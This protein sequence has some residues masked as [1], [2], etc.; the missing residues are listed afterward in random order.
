MNTLLLDPKKDKNT[1]EYAAD[2]LKKGGLV[3][4]PTETVYGLAADA[5][6]ENA[7]KSIYEA[8][9]RPSD[10]PLI[11]HIAQFEDIFPLVKSVPD[12]AKKLAES[13]WPG[14]LTIILPKSDKIPHCTSGG[15]DTVAIRMPSHPIARAVIKASGLPLAAPSANISGFPSPSKAEYA[16]DDMQ[17]RVP[18]VI[19]GGDCEVGVESTVI[20]LAAETPTVLRP[21]GI[22]VEQLKEV[23]G[24]V[25]VDDAVL[26]PL[27]KDASA[28]SPGMKY[29]HYSPKTQVTV[30]RGTEKGYIRYLLSHKQDGMF[31]L[32]FEE[33]ADKIP[34]PLI[35]YGKK[36]EP[37]T[38]SRRLFD[39][40]RELDEH[41]A[42]TAIAQC[43]SQN[44]L[45]LAVCN[46]LFRSAGFKFIYEAPIIGLTGQSG[47]GKSTVAEIFAENGF[48]IIDCDKIAREV[49]DDAEVLK[50]LSEQFGADILTED[51]KLNRR[52]L[53]EKAFS[54]AENTNKLNAVVHPAIL[55]KTVNA[56]YALS[57]DNIPCVIDAPL[58]F[59]C[60]LDE[61]CCLSVC[62]TAD[63]NVRLARI[64]KRDNIS[65]QECLKRFSI[66][67]TEKYY[68]DNADIIINNCANND[69]IADVRCKIKRIKDLYEKK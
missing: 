51:F 31:S 68:T 54:S 6:N 50:S 2:I 55:K 60:G 62:V 23:L 46:R 42:I 26:N 5:L 25:L 29:K 22:T 34:V 48:T 56:A 27:K 21:G 66:Q 45:G 61:I 38:Q 15:L 36:D 57:E 67:P 13:F 11:V 32:C 58:L 4:I 49:T 20:T 19:D 14:P 24:E 28:A 65:A 33:T 35:T 3:V 43:P 9:G 63:E 52:K 10:N 59:Q 47:A 17:G 44:G 18:V 12:N 30:Y 16:F 69:I 37:L 7:V 1:I 53:A 40:L 41:G 39:A 8:K 64:I